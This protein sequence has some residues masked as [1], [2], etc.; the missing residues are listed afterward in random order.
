MKEF[1]VRAISGVLYAALFL[2]SLQSQHALIA[3]FFVFGLITLAEFKKLINL[4]G[5]TTYII[6]ISNILHM[7]IGNW[8]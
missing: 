8:F 1:Y 7:L 4:K 3:L 2:I 5:V 6:F